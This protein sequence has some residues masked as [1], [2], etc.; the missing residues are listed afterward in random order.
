[1]ETKTKGAP[2]VDRVNHWCVE[3][4]RPDLCVQAPVKPARPKRNS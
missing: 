1:M 3:A 4:G 2:Y